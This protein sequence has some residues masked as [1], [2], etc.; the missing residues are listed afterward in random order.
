[1]DWHNIPSLQALRGFEAAVRAGSFSAAAR[2]LN[3][4]HAAIAQH[5][6]SLEAHLGQSLLVRD[7]RQMIPTEAGTSLAHD[8]SDGFAQIIAGVRSL[9]KVKTTSPVQVTLT[10]N[11]ADNWLMPRLSDFWARYPDITLSITPSND[12][13]DLRRDNFDLAIRYGTGHWKGCESAFLVKGDYAVVLHRDFLE[14]RE[15]KTISDLS[16]VPWLF[17]PT[18]PVYRTWAIQNGLDP[19][20]ITEREFPSMSLVA[21]AVRAGLGASVMIK[22]MVEEDVKSG[23]LVFFGQSCDPQLG[24]WVVTPKGVLQPKVSTVRKWLLSHAEQV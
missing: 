7:G 12:V 18:F 17:S 8:L 16:D 22:A 6:R 23:N 24:Y 19:S 11:F 21:A 14:G 3:V 13:V 2:E 9:E 1:M 15:A 20:A 10:P 4:T 5:V